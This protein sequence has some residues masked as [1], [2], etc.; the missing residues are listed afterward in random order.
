MCYTV[1]EVSGGHAS[2]LLA[3]ILFNTYSDSEQAARGRLKAT[4]PLAVLWASL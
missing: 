2:L 3:T 4:D 1:V